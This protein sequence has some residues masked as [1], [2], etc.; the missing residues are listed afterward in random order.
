MAATDT[1]APSSYLDKTTL[2]AESFT[3][4]QYAHTLVLRTNNAS[5]SPLDLSTP[6]AR[7]LFDAQEADTLIDSLATQHAAPI[8]DDTARRAEAAA[9]VLDGVEHQVQLLKEGYARLEREVGERYAAAEE[10]RLV[11]E[12]MVRTLRLGRAVQRVLVLGRQLEAQMSGL[13]GFEKAANKGSMVEAATTVVGLKGLLART[14]KGEEGEGL[15]RV[16][17]VNALRGEVMVPAERSLL[18]AAQQ[19]VREFS[20]SSLIG[21]GPSTS[22]GTTTPTFAQAEETKTKTTGALAALYLLSP[23]PAPNTTPELYTPTL[24]IQ[25]LQTY[26]HT[27]ITSSTAALARALATLP[28]LDRVLLDLSARSQNLL[29]LE[30]LLM[31]TPSPP[32]PLLTPQPSD[33]SLDPPNLLTALLKHLDTASLPSYFWRST[34]SQLSPRVQEILTRGGVS[35]RT[36]RSNVGRVRVAV[37]EC[38]DRGY[39]SPV[40]GLGAGMGMGSKSGESKGDTSTAVGWEREAAV[41]VQSIVGPLMK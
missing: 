28:T 33:P 29:A 1:T 10:V 31:T 32:H 21:T 39:K 8:V 38:V 36:L 5:D 18:A 7:V 19:V 40:S 24:L 27:T 20:M 3:P 15:A 41:M 9:R 37:R 6:L 34:A 12:R 30:S 26:L 13:K 11:A 16:G 35:A 23:I 25:A 4:Y 22:S 2:L 14:G 17:V